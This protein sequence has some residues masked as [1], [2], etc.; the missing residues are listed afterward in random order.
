MATE[1]DVLNVKIFSLW[2]LNMQQ[3]EQTLMFHV[4]IFIINTRFIHGWIT[5][6]ADWEKVQGPSWSGGRGLVMTGN[7][8]CLK[9]KELSQ[10][11]KNNHKDT[12]IYQRW[13]MISEMQKLQITKKK[14]T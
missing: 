10:K 2:S 5:E 7:I 11:T 8:S 14:H 6:R 12:E 13:K 9:A 3:R 1:L 4:S